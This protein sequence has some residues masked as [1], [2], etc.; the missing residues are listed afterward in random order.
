[1]DREKERWELAYQ[2]LGH[3]YLEFGEGTRRERQERLEE[4]WSREPGRVAFQCLARHYLE[5]GG[6]RV[7]VRQ[8][9]IRLMEEAPLPV[10]LEFGRIIPD[11]ELTSDAGH[12]PL[13]ALEKRERFMEG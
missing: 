4:F 11:V 1:M 10:L 9:V 6:G 8:Y 2:R 12:R 3:F 5:F 7:A 13:P